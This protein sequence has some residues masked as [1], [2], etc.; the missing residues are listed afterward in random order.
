MNTPTPFRLEIATQMLKDNLARRSRCKLAD[1]DSLER[2]SRYAA[3]PRV[4]LPPTPTPTETASEAERRS[5][6]ISERSQLI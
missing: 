4:C 2:E 5:H 3:A 6:A 1:V